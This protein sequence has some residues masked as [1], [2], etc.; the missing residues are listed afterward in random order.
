MVQTTDTEQPVTSE[1]VRVSLTH[2]L[3]VLKSAVKT[4]SSTI[5]AHVG[6]VK[7]LTY[8]LVQLDEMNR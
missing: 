3:K 2:H 1:D 8:L 7:A 4:D 6:A 5:I